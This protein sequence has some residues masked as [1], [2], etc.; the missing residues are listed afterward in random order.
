MQSLVSNIQKTFSLA[1][2]FTRGYFRTYKPFVG[3][4]ESDLHNRELMRQILSHRFPKHTPRT[5]KGLFHGKKPKSG[6]SYSHS[7]QA[8]DLSES[9]NF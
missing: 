7:D 1:N 4:K 3:L 2:V 8:Y 6:N 5:V 9:N